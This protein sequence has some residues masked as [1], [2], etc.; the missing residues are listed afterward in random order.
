MPK[1]K[2]PPPNVESADAL[3]RLFEDIAYDVEPDEFLLYEL[4]RLIE[5][6]RASFDDEEFRRAIDA[7]IRTHIG[8]RLEIR[9]EIAMRLRQ[10]LARIDEGMQGIVRRTLRAVEDVDFPLRNVSLIVRMYT[11][12]MFRRLHDTADEPLDLEY[13][14]RN[15]IERWQKGEIVREDL[16]PQLKR[17][18][19]PAVGPVA[20]LLLNA[21]GDRISSEAAVETLGAIRCS[22]SARVLAHA[23]SEPML[24]EDVESKAYE[25]ARAMWSLARNY[26]LFELAPHTHEDLPF[27]WFQ[28]MV[29]CDELSGVDLILEEVLTH[30]T[31]SNYAEDLLAIV[32]LLNHSRDPDVELKVVA[33]LNAPDTP[34]PAK[35]FLDS[36]LAGFQPK[37]Q[38]SDNPWSR[39]ARLSD[40]NRK[41][42]MA[43]R[44][45][46]SSRTAE[47]SRALDAILKAD[48]H[49]PFAVALKRLM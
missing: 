16:I 32:G 8:E 13:A 4:N 29:D 23:V 41:Y 39:A 19:H 15:L 7:G 18:G 24:D 22:S 20:D 25:A 47:A 46:E 35:R 10:A 44:L 33:L 17:L 42:R 40:L 43:A 6:D 30:S 27:R 21:S 28:L 9:A 5:E 1:R 38:P 2:T 34:E 11:A 26:I 12:Y 3:A 31:E 48:P 36:F 14:A 49:Y 45:Y 37:A